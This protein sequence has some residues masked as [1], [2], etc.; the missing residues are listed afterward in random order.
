MSFY[1]DLKNI[2]DYVES[3]LTG[4]LTK[5]VESKWN[6]ETEPRHLPSFQISSR[7][8]RLEAINDTCKEG[9]YDD[10]F[11][12]D[13]WMMYRRDHKVEEVDEM[14]DNLLRCLDTVILSQSNAE[15]YNISDSEI[16]RFPIPPYDEVIAFNF[17]VN[18]EVYKKVYA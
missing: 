11:S 14:N 5:T 6:S 2:S 16:F 10:R 9:I 8:D 17:K 15:R 1:S 7:T 13:C 12:L 4:S 18:L 3:N